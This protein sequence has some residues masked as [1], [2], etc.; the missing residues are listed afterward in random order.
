MKCSRPTW[1]PIA[2][3]V[4][5]TRSVIRFVRPAFGMGASGDGMTP[6]DSSSG[7]AAAATVPPSLPAWRAAR[8]ER[9][10]PAPLPS[11][12]GPEA[13]SRVAAWPELGERYLGG[14][15]LEHRF[16]RHPDRD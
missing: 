12:R 11:D 1:R 7:A 6:R 16:D 2:A 15:R 3:P 10:D 8:P 9:S 13:S 14:E 4:P 5:K